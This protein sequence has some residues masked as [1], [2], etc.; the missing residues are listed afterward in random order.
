[1]K[2]KILPAHITGGKLVVDGSYPDDIPILCLGDADSSGFVVFGDT[3]AIYLTNTQTDVAQIAAYLADL[4]E[5]VASTAG[6]V[7]TNGK[8]LS[9]EVQ[10]KALELKLNIEEYELK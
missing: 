10:V 2:T 1:M 7:A 6:S 8:P 5:M 9:P 3:R 4:S